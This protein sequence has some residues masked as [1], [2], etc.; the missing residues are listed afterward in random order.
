MDR[1]YRRLIFLYKKRKNYLDRFL[2]LNSK[3]LNNTGDCTEADLDRYFENRDM[4]FNLID[5]VTRNIKQIHLRGKIAYREFSKED[6]ESRE[7]IKKILKEDKKITD[8]ITA[9]MNDLA[10]GLKRIGDIERYT[11]I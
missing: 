2:S 3:F 8:E 1:N 5:T 4:L 6:S 10:N 11:A 9:Y 7:V